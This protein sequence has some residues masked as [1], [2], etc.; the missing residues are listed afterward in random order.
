[1]FSYITGCVKPNPFEPQFFL[2]Q[3]L[4][5]P[6]KHFELLRLMIPLGSRSHAPRP[7]ASDW[8]TAAPLSVVQILFFSKESEKPSFPDS[9]ASLHRV[10]F[11]YVPHV[12]FP[13]YDQANIRQN[14]ILP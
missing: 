7:I 8:S 12:G 13:W 4:L 6:Q 10:T 11:S 9:N 14:H 5:L 2:P 1:M 3:P